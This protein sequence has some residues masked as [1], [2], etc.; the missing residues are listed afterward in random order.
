MSVGTNIRR[1]RELKGLSQ[2]EL[3]KALGE[4]RQ[5]V[6]KYETGV[7][8]NIPFSKIEKIANILECSP[9]D[10]TGWQ[11]DNVVLLREDSAPYLSRQ[12]QELLVAW[13]RATDKEKMIIFAILEEYGFKR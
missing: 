5:T 11:R 6:Y 7:V 3:A 9:T 8:A 10:L 12:E 13:R 2:I 1:F 4:S